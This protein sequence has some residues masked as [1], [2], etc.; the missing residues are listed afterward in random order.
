MRLIND[1]FRICVAGHVGVGHVFSHSGF[2]QDD[3]LGFAALVRF[4]QERFGLN[5]VIESVTVADDTIKVVTSLGGVGV[6]KPRRGITPFEAKAI[7]SASGDPIFSWRLAL[8]LFGRFYG[9]GMSEVAVA[10]IYALSESVVD[11]LRKAI[12]DFRCLKS[13]D[14]V[15]SDIVCGVNLEYE[16]IPLT[17]LLTVNGSR[18][19]LGPC[20]D[21]EG[22]VY[23]GIK[24]RVLSSLRALRVPTIIV[25]SKA[26]N[27]ALRVEEESFVVR[28]NE[29]VD[30]PI[31]A[32]S[33]KEALCEL[34]F[35]FS[36]VNSAFP[37]TDRAS[38]DRE[39]RSFASRSLKTV[40]AISKA[41]T[42]RKKAILLGDLARL[43]SEDG[44]GIV[45]MSSSVN[46]VA[47]AVGLMPGTGAVISI[48]LPERYIREYKIPFITEKNVSDMVLVIR[49]ALPKLW[50]RIEEAHR[51][52]QVR[53][54]RFGG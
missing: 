16:G 49:K 38:I 36:V 32:R 13:D 31:V 44:G 1:G 15:S 26:Y 47:R 45:F 23:R 19:G 24:R 35:P 5:I 12:P 46:K 52:L 39:T 43:L 48:S 40:R 6:G 27:P 14:D 25:E 42:S 28:Y 9:N 17:L 41:K 50:G 18:L 34:G 29:E 10:F 30:N 22:N 20:E 21:L 8:E 53:C 11:S 7:E 51:L 54:N 33:L 3:S 4:I 37:L 2:V